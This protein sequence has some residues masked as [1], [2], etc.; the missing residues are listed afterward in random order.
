MTAPTD[1]GP[2][3]DKADPIL[4]HHFRGKNTGHLMLAAPLVIHNAGLAH[5]ELRQRRERQSIKPLKIPIHLIVAQPQREHIHLF[6][7]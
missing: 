5:K 7:L 3:L 2:C 6:L 4:L 1:V